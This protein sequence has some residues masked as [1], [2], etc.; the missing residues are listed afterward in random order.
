M[1]FSEQDTSIKLGDNAIK[2]I[3]NASGDRTGLSKDMCS[4]LDFI[5]NNSAKSN[6][7]KKLKDAV[8]EAI[9]KKEWEVDYMTLAMK[10][11]EEREDAEIERLIKASKK[12]N[13]PL[14]QIIEDIMSEFNL[15]K[16][17][18]FEKIKELEE[19]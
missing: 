18:V 3:V 14:N 11:V 12:Y 13:I 5:K 17:A 15:T 1:R 2:V 8:D 16:E 9:E 10:I 6:L 7:T 4:F 19:E